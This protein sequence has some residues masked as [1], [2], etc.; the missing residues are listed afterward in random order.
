MCLCFS[1]GSFPV[2][3]AFEVMGWQDGV[4]GTGG[5]GL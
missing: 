3:F 5:N 1:N 2:S 4:G